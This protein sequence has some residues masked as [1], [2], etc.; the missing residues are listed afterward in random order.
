LF[1]TYAL[2]ARFV[3]HG[4]VTATSLHAAVE[5]E[6]GSAGAMLETTDRCRRLEVDRTWECS[7]YDSSGSGGVGYEVRAREGSACFAGRRT[8]NYGEGGLP[9]RIS[10]CVYRWQW[11][12]FDLL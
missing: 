2:A 4:P 1:A 9:K 3:L 6:S 8:A 5:R 12:V 7:V 10:G 11:T